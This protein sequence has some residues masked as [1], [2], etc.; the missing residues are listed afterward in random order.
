MLRFLQLS[1]VRLGAAP[2]I[3][4]GDAL[5]AGLRGELR[6]DAGRA[7]ARACAL[8]AEHRVDAVIVA[9]GL[10]SNADC[11]ADDLRDLYMRVAELAPV[12]VIVVPGEADA[13]AAGSALHPRTGALLGIGARPDNLVV[14]GAGAAPF[15]VC[16]HAVVAAQ[17]SHFVPEMPSVLVA[18]GAVVEGQA[19]GTWAWVAA[20]GG[21][22][23]RVLV[24]ERGRALGG[25]PGA[26]VALELPGPVGGA[27]LVELEGARAELTA[28][29]TAPRRGWLVDLEVSGVER[30]ADLAELAHGALE[31]VGAR[32]ADLAWLRLSGCWR[33]PALPALAP[34]ALAGRVA[35]AWL[36]PGDL[37]L[38][39]P[40]GGSTADLHLRALMARADDGLEPIRLALSAWQGGS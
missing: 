21:G 33:L 10:V 20:G 22:E 11:T 40:T 37:T 35:C 14:L 15:V 38:S 1:D 39:P 27:W 28:L 8:A 29:A 34:D 13:L 30:A 12:P 17:A 6:G 16:E 9:G 26:P 19:D 3:M 25:D 32:A 4:S 5:P 31:R 2:R 23:P 24:D 36:Q 18:P 7:F